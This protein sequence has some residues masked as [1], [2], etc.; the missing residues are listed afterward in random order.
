MTEHDTTSFATDDQDPHES[1][2]TV[3]WHATVPVDAGGTP[4]W[5]TKDMA[6][7]CCD[8]AD[9]M[10]LGVDEDTAPA[11]V[12]MLRHTQEALGDEGILTMIEAIGDSLSTELPAAQM[13]YQKVRDAQ[14]LA[15]VLRGLDTDAALAVRFM[16]LLETSRR[17]AWFDLMRSLHDE[18]AEPLDPGN[19]FEEVFPNGLPADPLE[20][21]AA[22]NVAVLCAVDFLLYMNGL[23]TPEIEEAVAALI[24][25]CEPHLQN[26]FLEGVCDAWAVF[27]EHPESDAGWATSV[28][29]A[30]EALGD[31][32]RSEVL[33]DLALLGSLAETFG[34][35]GLLLPTDLS[36]ALDRHAAGTVESDEVFA[37]LRE[38]GDRLRAAGRRVSSL[39]GSSTLLALEAARTERSANLGALREPVAG[40]ADDR[41]LELSRLRGPEEVREHIDAV[42]ALVSALLDDASELPEDLVALH[43]LVG[44][45]ERDVADM[46]T[47]M[48]A[49]PMHAPL[50][51]VAYAGDLSIGDVSDASGD[52]ASDEPQEVEPPAPAAPATSRRPS[53]EDRKAR[54][55][56]SSPRG[57]VRLRR[58]PDAVVEAL[59]AE[60]T[61]AEAGAQWAGGTLPG[62]TPASA[63]VNP[64]F[65]D[66]DPAVEAS[67]S[68]PAMDGPAATEA[69]ESGDGTDRDSGS[70]AVTAGDVS[71]ESPAA[72]DT[73]VSSA[74]KPADLPPA[75]SGGAA[76]DVEASE[77]VH[78]ALAPGSVARLVVVDGLA[79]G[80]FG[81][82]HHAAAAVGA[83]EE[84][85]WRFAALANAVA[86]GTGPIAGAISA[87]VS[88]LLDAEGGLVGTSGERGAVEVAYLAGVRASLVAPHSA[89]LTVVSACGR[90]LPALD[91]LT[92]AVT[93]SARQGVALIDHVL[94][95]AADLADAE[96]RVARAADAAKRFKDETATRSIKYHRAT[97]VL[98]TLIAD[99]GL[100]GSLLATTASD[101]TDGKSR[102]ERAEHVLRTV[103]ELRSD[104]AAEDVIDGAH[105][106]GFEIHSGA[107][108][109]LL[110]YWHAALD[111]AA[112]WADAVIALD[113]SH[114]DDTAWQATFLHRLQEALAQVGGDL[115]RLVGE[116]ESD[117]SDRVRAAGAACRLLL[118]S[119]RSLLVGERP[120]AVSAGPDA[121]VN[122]DLAAV[123]TVR[124]DADWGL[125]DP[126]DGDLILDDPELTQLHDAVRMP[127]DQMLRSAF[128]ARLA[129]EDHVATASI[130]SALTAFVASDSTAAIMPAE[131]DELTEADSMAADSAR[132]AVTQLWKDTESRLAADARLGYLDETTRRSWT[133]DLY[134]VDPVTGRNDLGHCRAAITEIRERSEQNRAA[135]TAEIREEISAAAGAEPEIA[136]ALDRIMD[137]VDA[138]DLATAW[139]YVSLAREGA[140]I[141]EPTAP[142]VEVDEFFPHRDRELA[143]HVSL[144][145]RAI[146]TAAGRGDA[147]E[148]LD[149][150]ALTPAD[151]A[152]AKS[153]LDAWRAM[154]NIA[155][156]GKEYREWASHLPSVLT[157]LGMTVT[158]FERGSLTGE[159]EH[160]RLWIE[161]HDLTTVGDPVVPAFAPDPSG[162][163]VLR[164]LA[165]TGNPDPGQLEAAVERDRSGEPVLLLHHGHIG[166][167]ARS[168]AAERFRAA[169]R[170]VAIVDDAVFAHLMATGPRRYERTMGTVLPFVTSNPYH[171]DVSG[172]VP[173]TM[174]FGRR[175]ELAAIM[176]RHGTC[177]LYGGRQLGKSATLRMA[178]RSFNTVE[179]H[180]ALYLDLKGAQVG[181][182][183]P[184]EAVF[185]ALWGPLRNA[186][187]VEGDL[188]AAAITDAVCN[189]IDRW[190]SERAGRRLLVLLD[191]CDQFLKADAAQDLTT[192]A[193]LKN[194]MERTNRACKVVFAGL[195]TVQ[196]FSGVANTPMA[197]LGT[198]IAIGPLEG[199]AAAELIT[200]PLYALGYRFSDPELVNRILA[201]TSRQPALLVIFCHH[202][203]RKLQAR[204]RLRGEPP[205]SITEADVDGTWSDPEVSAAIRERVQWTLGLDPA[206]EVITYAIA[207]LT[208]S[209]GAGTG[210]DHRIGVRE[211]E[212]ECTYWWS[213]GFAGLGG[214]QFRL[215]ADELIGLGVLAKD[216]SRYGLRNP[217]VA[218]LLGS[219]E[220][221]EAVLETAHTKQPEQVF[222]PATWRRQVT[223]EA[224]ETFRSPLSHAQLDRI[225][226]PAI[227]ATMVTGTAAAGID[228][229]AAT[230]ET[231]RPARTK[232]TLR[233]WEHP[234]DAM[235]RPVGEDR[236]R[237]AVIDLRRAPAQRARDIIATVAHAV[238]PDRSRTGSRGTWSVVLVADAA[239]DGEVVRHAA[240]VP[241]LSTMAIQRW[242]GP[243]IAA[244]GRDAGYPF[245]G[246][247][248]AEAV[249]E[250][251]GGWGYLVGQVAAGV[252]G[253]T[254]LSTVLEDLDVTGL[255][256]AIGFTDGPVLAAAF[257]QVRA[258]LPDEA[259]A[260]DV[261]T[262][263]EILD[264]SPEVRE[265][266]R[267]AVARHGLDGSAAGAL[268]V[269]QLV[270]ADL[271]VHGAGLVWAEPVAA[272]ALAGRA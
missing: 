236:H 57:A 221:I 190:L 45:E 266:L 9:A 242:S 220:E 254:T 21:T 66:A 169:G 173:E 29:E 55:V 93:V 42:V 146:A 271:L 6:Q 118:E 265:A 131:L 227:T 239:R 64:P 136:R 199:S 213:E 124:L 208:S 1:G 238:D 150:S 158:T 126:P 69:S 161:L 16:Q 198:P 86:S 43:R 191:E 61:K 132:A 263:A 59:V 51:G 7:L 141:P 225:Y 81:A 127:R 111:I 12:A 184:P 14:W 46:T 247:S 98:R 38:R 233:T 106:R 84:T 138:G 258:L 180:V 153:A 71:G 164:V 149:F 248:E 228:Q 104:G 20:R 73:P 47:F 145:A 128:E 74:P 134:A 27:S 135:R 108:Q 114:H 99:T 83:E 230:I 261:E 110:A 28:A 77:H 201:H 216:G 41:L 237:I 34:T 185:E 212:A 170:A 36:E 219:T 234:I 50:A 155:R 178:A 30:L 251:T 24:E 32:D 256:E 103:T 177:F 143:E 102:R 197:H 210:T 205:F 209:E 160:D 22:A 231:A 112:D 91:E 165:I 147:Y 159:R 85:V 240:T 140:D 151:Q 40:V 139:E 217:N 109:R 172:L 206:Y 49:H 253:A 181:M 235:L 121:V 214:E 148:Q 90:S 60:A 152:V 196:R 113:A 267:V 194:L 13:P 215:L 78:D 10:V 202:L 87:A 100:L 53:G 23:S 203:L 58:K 116:L 39:I 245:A 17:D 97:G 246:P 44:S 92:E 193:R 186:G 5:R 19:V 26:P 122:L 183:H 241:A 268:V 31:A 95:Q 174:F 8:L 68:K 76:S 167:E 79:A 264:E 252:A 70:V 65:P 166:P 75:T 48:N 35:T 257:R 243:A 157:A 88:E 200:K 223:T 171:L 94:A 232:V 259:S 270:A 117:P 195:H 244:Y 107:R 156:P 222:E 62:V 37:L 52:G 105:T 226:Q 175:A 207:H 168:D 204:R 89:A 120:A 218:R 72:Q 211:L 18:D 249:A 176:D 189:G 67:A 133:A 272:R 82:A 262:L 163:R 142:A 63:I 25:R 229:V 137:R 255:A 260:C 154:S 130:L 33:E 80:R 187:I 115:D 250:R 101:H 54:L 123:P 3:L 4:L 224:G 11:L 2:I 129:A 179:N 162:H 269:E 144:R 119:I 15:K 125:V 188:P 192:S 56:P 182:P 96:R